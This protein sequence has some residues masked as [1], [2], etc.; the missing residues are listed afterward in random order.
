[1][2]RHTTAR[3]AAPSH[4][5][6]TSEGPADSENSGKRRLR[7]LMSRPMVAAVPERKARDLTGHKIARYHIRVPCRILAADVGRGRAVA[8][9]GPR[10]GVPALAG[11]DHRPT[12][13]RYLVADHRLSRF[14]SCMVNLL[15]VLGTLVP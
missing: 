9:L 3:V 14:R 11:P 4:V 7:P 13:R 5:P 6:L 2:V 1:M 8:C 15:L 10:I 12:N